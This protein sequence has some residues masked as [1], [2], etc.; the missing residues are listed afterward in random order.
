MER[1]QPLITL[2]TDFAVQSQ[3]I[4]AMEV[5]IYSIAPDAK[6]IHLMHGLPEFDLVAAAR[7]MET[8]LYY[9][10]GFHVCVCDPGVGT[11]RKALAI[12]TRR[13]DYLI[14]PDNGLFGPAIRLLG[15]ATRVHQL[16]NPELMR[17]P[18]SPIFHGRDIFAPAAAHLAR[19][20]RLEDFGPAVDP[21]SLVAAAYEEAKIEGRTISATI[22]QINRFGSLHL[23]VLAAQWNSLNITPGKKVKCQFPLGKNAEVMVGEKFGDVAPGEN[24]IMKDDYG[25]VEVAKNL[26]SFVS[27]FPLRIGDELRIVF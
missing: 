18:V 14:G 12:E 24:L 5:T 27:E 7:T 4:G 21:Q 20:I 11:S 3:G 22:I 9:P 19:G 1:K 15:G 6:V 16:L 10:V 17:Q 8:V 2:T 23:N 13:G 25:R 26:G